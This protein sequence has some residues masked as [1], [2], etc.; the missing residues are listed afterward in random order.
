MKFAFC[1]YCGYKLNDEFAF[2]PKCGK[3]LPIDGESDETVAT[4]SETVAKTDETDDLFGGALAGV[5]S[6]SDDFDFS[7]VDKALDEKIKEKE[8]LD[9]KRKLIRVLCIRGK[10]DEATALCNELLESDP[11]DYAA[12]VGFVRIESK[13]YT[14]FEGEEIEKAVE[15]V[16]Q[17][18]STD[19]DSDADFSAYL[20]KR[21]DY[22]AEKKAAQLKAEEERKAKA[23]A[24]RKAKEEADRKAKE[25]AE[26][27]AK[28]KEEF[29]IEGTTLKEF[30]KREYV[31]EVVI[32]DGISL[33][34]GAFN[35]CK[36]TSV[37]IP[38][39]VK[40][41]NSGA[42]VYCV[43]LVKVIVAESN[44]HY[45]SENNCIIE[46]ST[47]KLIVGCKTSEIPGDVTAIGECSFCGR[48]LTNIRLPNGVKTI[49][50]CAFYKC[51]A[52][53]RVVVPNGVSVI[54]DNAFFGCG[55]LTDVFIPE[56]V[57]LIDFYAFAG[58]VNLVKV[59]VAESNPHY[60]SENNCIIEKSTKKLIVGCKTSKIPS[61]VLSIGENA[62]FGCKTLRNI[63]IPS[64]VETIGKDAFYGCESLENVIIPNSVINIDEHAFYGCKSLKDIS[65]PYS[66]KTMGWDV[67]NCC[68]S[69]K[70]I[71]YEGSVS[72]WRE[73]TGGRSV[74]CCGIHFKK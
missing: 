49:E 30:K 2:C 71:N 72:E 73:I 74:C 26:R 64:G 24:E 35:G 60:Y 23:E 41:I 39:S 67:F 12:Y 13:N 63:S 57:K 33:I 38:G 27:K 18:F 7:L 50:R 47:K 20:K 28:I 45:Y 36:L 16:R 10:F 43:N 15:V 62:F 31:G 17:I 59:I 32:P 52:L 70:N 1:P 58:C 40:L 14:A 6:S 3:R 61:D 44:P 56:S 66:V 48:E 25:E 5:K 37:I 8:E 46:K 22:F 9:K 42:F 21:G 53:Q 55:A 29:K 19:F 4:P 11:E 65:I 54:G 68:D 51:H 34:A 69:L